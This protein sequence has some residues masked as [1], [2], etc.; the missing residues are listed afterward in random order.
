MGQERTFCKHV[1]R[2]AKAMSESTFF[3]AQV[4]YQ[5]FEAS[6]RADRKSGR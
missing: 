2:G 1:E 5:L 6:Q 3:H 4:G